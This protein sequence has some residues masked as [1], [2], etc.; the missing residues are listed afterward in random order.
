V[1]SHQHL[2]ADGHEED[3]LPGGSPGLLA[4]PGAGEGFGDLGQRVVQKPPEYWR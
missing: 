4:E 3:G 1:D 2:P